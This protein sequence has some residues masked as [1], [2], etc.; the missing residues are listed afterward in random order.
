MKKLIVALS[1]AVCTLRVCAGTVSP[2]G[3]DVTWNLDVT[4]GYYQA[5][6]SWLGGVAPTGVGTNTG[7]W[8]MIPSGGTNIT[9]KFPAGGYYDQHC[10]H[11]FTP[12]AQ[13]ARTV[14]L[15]ATGTKWVKG[16][17]NDTDKGH[18]YA[19][20]KDKGYDTLRLRNSANKIL[21][22]VGHQQDD[23]NKL[24]CLDDGVL[25]FCSDED[26]NHDIY[27]DSGVFSGLGN[28]VHF[29]LGTKGYPVNF[30]VAEDAR[31]G[32]AMIGTAKK[33]FETI[34]VMS[35]DFN[36]YGGKHLARGN[37]LVSSSDDAKDRARFIVSGEG[38]SFQAANLKVGTG[39]AGSYAQAF[40]SGGAT[41][42]LIDPNFHGGV[43]EVGSTAS[44]S[45]E[46]TGKLVMSDESKIL[47]VPTHSGATEEKVH[48]CVRIGTATKTTG[49]IEMRDHSYLQVK[50]SMT[51]GVAQNSHA[52]VVL[53]N[54]AQVVLG[55]GLYIGSVDSTHDYARLSLN[56]EAKI[57][58]TK[59]VGRHHEACLEANGGTIVIPA[60]S[61]DA[62]FGGLTSATLAEKGLTIEANAALDLAQ[63]FTGVGELRIAG[64][65][66][67][68]IRSNQESPLVLVKG[69]LASLDENITLG[70]V[71]ADPGTKL[72]V[73][74][75]VTIQELN[76][77]NETVDV[78]VGAAGRLT[79]NRLN[80]T[81]DDAIVKIAKG[82]HIQLATTN[83]IDH[84]LY[85]AFDG[86]FDTAGESVVTLPQD[87]ADTFT[88]SM[89]KVLNIATGNI[90]DIEVAPDGK[91]L[92][93]KSAD[94]QAMDFVWNGGASGDWGDSTKWLVGGVVPPRAPT[95]ND[96]VTITELDTPITIT[97]VDGDGVGALV[98]TA[99]ANGVTNGVTLVSA[100][101]SSGMPFYIDN[102]AG[103]VVNA[104]S[105]VFDT[106]VFVEPSFT[107]SVAADD[108]A[109]LEF[110][111]TIRS[112]GKV[113]FT[114]EG[115]GRL[116]IAGDNSALDVDW[117]IP[118]GINTFVGVNAF[119][120]DTVSESGLVL[121]NNTLRYVA[122][123]GEV[124]GAAITRNPWFKGRFPTRFDIEGDLTFKGFKVLGA[125]SGVS[126]SYVKTGVGTL[127]FELTE[128]DSKNG[129]KCLIDKRVDPTSAD[130]MPGDGRGTNESRVGD[131]DI[132]QF[133]PTSNGMVMNWVGLTRVNVFEGTLCIRGTGSVQRPD[134]PPFAV[135][136][137]IGG[138]GYPIRTDAE[139]HIENMGISFNG[140]NNSAAFILGKSGVPGG[141]N[142]PRL[143]LVDSHMVENGFYVSKLHGWATNTY[144]VLTMTNSILEAMGRGSFGIKNDQE[145]KG[146]IPT[147][148]LWR[149]TILNNSTLAIGNANLN[150][151]DG[152]KFSFTKDPFTTEMHPN[153]F[154]IGL[155]DENYDE[156]GPVAGKEKIM[157]KD[158]SE[159][160]L[161]YFN[162]HTWTARTSAHYLFDGGILNLSRDRS[163][164]ATANPSAQGFIVGENSM[165]VKVTNTLS[166]TM[167]MPFC[168]EGQIAKI[169][170]G[171]CVF[172]N[173]YQFYQDYAPEGFEFAANTFTRTN[174]KILCNQGGLKVEGGTAVVYPTA[175]TNDA[176]GTFRYPFEVCAGATL[177]FG[178][179]TADM[180]LSLR[181]EGVVS[182]GGIS[183]DV[184]LAADEG[185]PLVFDNFALG[186]NV[187]VEWPMP[188]EGIRP[189][190]NTTY[191]I[192]AFSSNPPASL[193]NWKSATTSDYKLEFSISPE[194]IVNGKIVSRRGFVIIFR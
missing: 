154:V 155:Y 50:Y 24:F 167:A 61:T 100:D 40:I 26:G 116:V 79:L 188:E 87:S 122:K 185:Q 140:W 86:D 109:S 60:T 70:T 101:A 138:A 136:V 25:R 29:Y 127:T 148:N 41:L 34:N 151:E 49:T 184:V 133:V 12:S 90:Y 28:Q 36:V 8:A 39:W 160:D 5:G 73:N 125:A 7:D 191:Q 94:A 131:Y 84:A 159:L 178:G 114:K 143:T 115:L 76:L 105:L 77:T 56:D 187:R 118:G 10:L 80:V 150:L 108:A 145:T 62:S 104:G 46:G 65:G 141:C 47:C 85:L 119:G 11:I 27:L 102:P 166:H 2:N 6:D 124:E 96:K 33:A 161:W 89:F 142:H 83:G 35:G 53:S 75:A 107:V 71:T 43:L 164:T 180:P 194:G 176:S 55:T 126:W 95:V 91:R 81:T 44:S 162:M 146:D 137:I 173:A 63:T 23:Y 135:G 111:K 144:A 165:Y 66:G 72:S 152:S 190:P 175:L 13:K 19:W 68:M 22:S 113:T 147:I 156:N 110:R 98:V 52:T 59:V 99:G 121:S 58:A 117:I 88:S 163:F 97:V 149:S 106:P 31:F 171:I 93:V 30:H 82:G 189:D 18:F 42:T 179:M 183:A 9:I 57:T 182:D 128:S 14:T 170:G 15:D 181:G 169:G 132:G 38:T 112:S 158:G 129:A 177:S 54:A 48:G 120:M 20:G 3:R 67:V 153:T 123:A 139:L 4:N 186:G 16:F 74:A 64:A 17:E 92:N 37:V 78:N 21:F 172:T 174:Q 103:I 192:A 168:G 51:L 32:G 193:A 130:L 1:A 157:V 69:A 134:K 45:K